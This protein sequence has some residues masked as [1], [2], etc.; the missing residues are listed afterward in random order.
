MDYPWKP[1]EPNGDRA[2]NCARLVKIDNDYRWGDSPW[3]QDKK[4][5][6]NG[7]RED[8]FIKSES[9]AL[10]YDNSE[11]EFLMNRATVQCQILRPMEDSFLIQT[12]FINRLPTSRDNK[13]NVVLYF[14]REVSCK[15]VNIL[16]ILTENCS[17]KNY[18]EKCII[19]GESQGSGIQKHCR[20]DCPIKIVEDKV[21]MSLITNPFYHPGY[22]KLCEMEIYYTS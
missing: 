1:G 7:P 17:G 9:I 3:N 10:L 22:A 4:Y 8:G 13:V 20:Y 16:K 2:V 21:T 15:E 14:D 18:Y 12:L 11:W 19:S 5:I 6:C